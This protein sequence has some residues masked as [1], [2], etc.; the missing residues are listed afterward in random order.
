MGDFE[1]AYL[2]FLIFKDVNFKNSLSLAKSL[3]APQ[4]TFSPFGFFSSHLNNPFITKYREDY[5]FAMVIICSSL[6][7]ER[8]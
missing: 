4:S 6:Y 1:N 3:Q 5:D 7:Y 8:I 2:A